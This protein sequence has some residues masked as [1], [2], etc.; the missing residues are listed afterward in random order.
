[1]SLAD[2]LARMKR[3][4]KNAEVIFDA[5]EPIGAATDLVMPRRRWFRRNPPATGSLEA[6]ILEA[7]KWK[8]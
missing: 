1:M 7:S 6:K 2:F 4:N 5:E 8:P 3:Y